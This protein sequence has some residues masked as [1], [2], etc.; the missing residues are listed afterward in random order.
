MCRAS[1]ASRHGCADDERPACRASLRQT[2]IVRNRLPCHTAEIEKPEPEVHRTPPYGYRGISVRNPRT[3]S[4]HVV[5]VRGGR[6]ASTDGRPRSR[7]RPQRVRTSTSVMTR[8][9]ETVRCVNTGRV[10][11]A[12]RSA[13]CQRFVGANTHQLRRPRGSGRQPKPCFCRVAVCSVTRGTAI[14]LSALKRSHDGRH[15]RCAS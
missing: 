11:G 10:T 6:T 3:H 13:M 4:R 14:R 9:G 7:R 5:H 8:P 15:F 12:L 2:R 1:R